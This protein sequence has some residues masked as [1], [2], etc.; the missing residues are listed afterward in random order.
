[1]LDVL[2][3]V[4]NGNQNN[5]VLNSSDGDELELLESLLENDS[6]GFNKNEILKELKAIDEKVKLDIGT[7]EN[8]EFRDK[9]NSIVSALEDSIRV[10]ETAWEDKNR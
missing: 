8:I 10:V 2:E 1:M 4:S 9:L 5:S 7:E 6:R 3:S